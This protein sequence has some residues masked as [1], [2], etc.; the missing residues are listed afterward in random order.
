MGL[1]FSPI[2]LDVDT[3][4]GS[5]M[6]VLR[7]GALVAVITELGAMHGDQSGWWFIETVFNVYVPIRKDPF[8]DIASLDDWLSTRLEA[9]PL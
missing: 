5:G 3:G 2:A 7:G 1:Q 4:D 6:L 9:E 8:P